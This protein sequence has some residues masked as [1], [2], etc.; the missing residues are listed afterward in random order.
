MPGTLILLLLLGLVITIPLGLW[1]MSAESGAVR[2]ILGLV[3]TVVTLSVSATGYQIIQKENSK[4]NPYSN[5]P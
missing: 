1:W 2:M 3:I 4:P 5:Y